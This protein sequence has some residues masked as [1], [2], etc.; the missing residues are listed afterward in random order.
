MTKLHYG[1]A[2]LLKCQLRKII[3]QLLQTWGNGYFRWVWKNLG[4]VINAIFLKFILEWYLD[5]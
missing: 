3:L 2:K 5:S 1:V 4:Q